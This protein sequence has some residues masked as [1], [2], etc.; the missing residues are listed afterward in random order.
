MAIGIGVRLATIRIEGAIIDL[1][2]KSEGIREPHSRETTNNNKRGN[3]EGGEGRC[4]EACFVGR[5]QWG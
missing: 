5:W 1:D 4:I 2:I 3:G